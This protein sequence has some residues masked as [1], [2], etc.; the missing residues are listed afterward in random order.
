RKMRVR[1]FITL[2]CGDD[3][4][5]FTSVGDPPRGLDRAAEACS[6]LRRGDLRAAIAVEPFQWT[7]D[8]NHEGCLTDS[9]RQ[10]PIAG[11]SRSLSRLQRR[12]LSQAHTRGPQ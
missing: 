7:H 12:V 9:E 8:R 11:R 5:H 10:F 6:L 2:A 3:A 4:K 1:G